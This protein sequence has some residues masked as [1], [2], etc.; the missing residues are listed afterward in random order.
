MGSF[1]AGPFG[2]ALRVFLGA[3]VGAFYL[4]LQNGN[5]LSDLNLGALQGFVTAGLVVAVPIAIA[6]LNPADGRFGRTAAK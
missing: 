3:V 5:S 4:Y 2:S 6:A 1:L